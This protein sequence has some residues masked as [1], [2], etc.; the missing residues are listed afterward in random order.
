[1]QRYFLRLILE[2]M[3]W[4]WIGYKCSIHLLEEGHNPSSLFGLVPLGLLWS[5]FH[6]SSRRWAMFYL[7]GSNMNFGLLLAIRPS[8][9]GGIIRYLQG[10][11]NITWLINA[12]LGTWT[13]WGPLKQT[14]GSRRAKPVLFDYCRSLGHP[15][16]WDT[17]TRPYIY[18]GAVMLSVKE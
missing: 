14:L 18:Y 11:A 3:Q 2:H 5:S 9:L 15:D 4:P 12:W 16:Y 7:F 8:G 10:K 6:R 1:M 17:C 13:A